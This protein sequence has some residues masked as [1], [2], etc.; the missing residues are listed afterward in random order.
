[1]GDQYEIFKRISMRRKDKILLTSAA[2]G[3]AGFLL[4]NLWKQ[5]NEKKGK[6]EKLTWDNYDALK[7]IQT[8]FGGAILGAAGGYVYYDYKLSEE[9]S[10]PFNSDSYLN[11]IL[12]SENLKSDP[13]FFQTMLLKRQEIK[14]WISL[15][16]GSLLASA[17]E[18]AG[19]FAKKTAISSN[20]DLDII[21]PFKRTSYCIDPLNSWTELY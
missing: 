3:G 1:M 18:D 20:Y 4:Y 8:L 13:E 9:A 7:G 2:I 5:W 14:T 10:I 17:P 6:N 15:K 21:I 12:S 11:K 19:S 16:F